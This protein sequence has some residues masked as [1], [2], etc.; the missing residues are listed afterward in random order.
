MIVA[1]AVFGTRPLGQLGLA[2]V[3]LVG[4][5]VAVVRFGRHD[6]RLSRAISPLRAHPGQPV[7]LAIKV[8]NRASSTAPLLLIEDRVPA[9]LSGTARF[10]L[11]GVEPQGHREAEIALTAARRGRYEVGPTQISIVDPFGL[12]HLRSQVLERSSFLVHPRIENLAMPLDRGDRRSSSMSSLRQPTGSRGEDFY[13]LREYSEGDDLRKIHW[14]STAKRARYMIRQEE[15]PW[16]TRATILLDDRAGAHDGSAAYS[17]FE[18]AVEATASLVDLYHRSAYSY[19]LTAAHEQ[20]FPS[21]KRAEHL[22]RC[23]DLLATIHP[24]RGAAAEDG[25]VKRLSE[26]EAGSIE[27]ALV[28]VSGTL[29]ERDALALTRVRKRLRD[30]TLITFP[31]HRFSGQTTKRR[32]EGEQSLMELVQLLTRSGVRALA[33]G[34]DDPLAP[35]WMGLCPAGR[36]ERTWAR[37][38]EL[39]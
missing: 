4:V 18:R 29:R 26:I 3:V 16:Q 9:A 8:H 17:S 2:L 39:V 31:A 27:A 6:L 38:P 35:A 23:L 5:A 20:G 37:R 33:L 13:T 34:P 30:V 21:A 32:W 1:G 36:Q 25:L 7:T 14:P 22:S 12:A 10:A 24:A 19:R 28:V 11:K 15:T